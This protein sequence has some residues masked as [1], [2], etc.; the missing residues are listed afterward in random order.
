MAKH[1]STRRRASLPLAPHVLAAL[2]RVRKSFAVL[3][4]VPLL[5]DV[6]DEI[7]TSIFCAATRQFYS[8]ACSFA[9]ALQCS[10]DDPAHPPSTTIKE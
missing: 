4:A 1:K 9:F 7:K 5:A 8:D 3:N 10:V 6:P 2:Q